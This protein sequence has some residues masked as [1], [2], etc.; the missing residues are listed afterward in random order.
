[1]R[2]RQARMDIVARGGMLQ[3]TFRIWEGCHAESVNIFA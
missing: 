1:M 3:P 2:L